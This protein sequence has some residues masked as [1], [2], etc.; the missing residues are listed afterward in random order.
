MAD[1]L[2]VLILED[3]PSDAELVRRELHKSGLSFTS[4]CV[5]SRDD[6]L[7]LLDTFAPDIILSDYQMPQFTGM[8]ALEMVQERCPSVPLIIVTGAINEETAVACMQA[9]AADYVIKEHLSRL[10]LAVSGVLEK[11][12]IQQQKE[13]A[14]QAMQ[15]TARQWRASFDAIS[16]A[17]CMLAEDGSILR[18]NKAMK[19]LLG[20]PWKSIVGERCWEVVH[21]TTEPIPGCPNV[22]MH[23]EKQRET[24]VVEVG[25]RLFEVGV[26]PVLNADGNIDGAVHIMSDVTERHHMEQALRLADERLRTVLNSTPDAIAVTDLEGEITECNATALTMFGFRSKQELIGKSAFDLISDK[27]SKRAANLLA[28][29]LRGGALRNIEYTATTKD[30]QEF[31]AEFS[32]S[33][34]RESL[35]RPTSIVATIRDISERKQAEA[36]RLRLEAQLRHQQKLESIGTLAGG[37][38]HEINN[39]INGIMNYAQ[40]IADRIEEDNSI[41]EYAREIISET[42]RVAVIVRNL[43]HF[44]RYETPPYSLATP[45]DIIHDTLS[46]VHTVLR[47]DQ[48]TLEIEIPDGL[49]QIHCRSQQIQQVLMNLITNARDALNERHA[50][51]HE[52][53][54]LRITAGEHVKEGAPWIRISVEDH[55][56]GID[57]E[58]RQ[59][60][61]DPFFTTKPKEIGTGLGLSISHGIVEE[62]AGRLW[63]ESKKEEYTRFHLELPANQSP[64]RP[65]TQSLHEGGDA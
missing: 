50:E 63:F 41:G 15:D 43:L 27:E 18:C 11:K 62:H 19:D 7:M 29:I 4:T 28:Q 6:F 39:P 10:G 64:Q 35:E 23:A 42:K 52:Q 14:E 49:P 60:I 8:E 12:R 59:R 31:P 51:H 55:G 45:A 16:D 2:R 65:P 46:L 9:G 20:K 61:F 17:V 21:G 32:A 48:I 56:T 36:E 57:A 33:V 13:R 22:R 25:D 34:M 54:V 44:A 58:I 1:E 24:E 38:A 53:K 26:D 5:D 37:V 3:I 40:L 30:G 47:H